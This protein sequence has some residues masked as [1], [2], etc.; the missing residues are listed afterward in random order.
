M[1]IPHDDV[2]QYELLELLNKAKNGTMH[3]NDVYKQ[4]AKLFPELTYDDTN[5]PYRNSASL[6]ANRVQFARLHCV[7]KGQILSAYQGGSRGHGYWTITEKGRG[8]RRL[9]PR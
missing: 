3:C 6:W 8:K 9:A 1:T 4:L 5:V 7:S 2:I